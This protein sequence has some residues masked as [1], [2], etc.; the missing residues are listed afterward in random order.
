VKA[1]PPRRTAAA[2]YAS[3][4]R[5]LIAALLV[6]AVLVKVRQ[7]DEADAI[8][9]QREQELARQRMQ[10]H[11]TQ[12]SAMTQPSPPAEQGGPPLRAQEDKIEPFV[13][14]LPKVGRNDPC[15]CGSGRKY[16]VCHGR[17]A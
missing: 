14:D 8:E 7:E 12:A 10:F 4:R 5:R 17:L 2:T 9:R 11:H 6:I 13:R 15:P 16:K 1:P 3:P